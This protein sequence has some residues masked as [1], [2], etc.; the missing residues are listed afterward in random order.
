L[1]NGAVE[2]Q[3]T[4]CRD[5]ARNSSDS[6]IYRG[7]FLKISIRPPVVTGG[8]FIY[9]RIVIFPGRAV[10][11]FLCIIQSLRKEGF[12]GQDQKR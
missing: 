2:N 12:Y 9:I 4:A 8:F 1:G 3:P 10:T 11:A 7:F 6:R 5:G